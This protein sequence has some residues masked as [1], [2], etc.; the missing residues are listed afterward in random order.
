VIT[1]VAGVG[2]F[3]L[4]SRGRALVGALVGPGAS[5][6]LMRIVGASSVRLSPDE[7]FHVAMWS[8]LGGLASGG[9]AE[10][11][12]TGPEPML[13]ESDLGR[14]AAVLWVLVLRVGELVIAPY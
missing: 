9:I 13:V 14:I 8:A 5:V 7:A 2:G 1:A 6:L 4:V 3:S 10:R 12:V 11:F